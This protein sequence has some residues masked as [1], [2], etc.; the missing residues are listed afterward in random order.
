VAAGTASLWVDIAGKP[1]KR[2]QE[3]EVRDSF[4]KA[5]VPFVEED[6]SRLEGLANTWMAMSA[7]A[8]TFAVHKGSVVARRLSSVRRRGVV[9]TLEPLAAV[10]HIFARGE[11]EMKWWWRSISKWRENYWLLGRHSSR[12]DPSHP[13]GRLGGRKRWDLLS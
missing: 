9:G 13:K 6:S 5:R 11:A 7:V 3:V 1:S 4:D 12:A 8:G 2:L 10:E